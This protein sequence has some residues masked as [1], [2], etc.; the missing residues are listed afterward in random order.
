MQ[1]TKVELIYN[2]ALRERYLDKKAEFTKLANT[3]AEEKFVF[4]GTDTT[5]IHNISKEG[6]KIGGE[7][8][9][10][11]S[12]AAF[13][14]GVYTAVNPDTSIAYSRGSNMM[15]LSLALSGILGT[16]HSLGGGPQVIVLKNVH[17]LLPK[18]VVHY[19]LN[20]ATNS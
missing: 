14:R 8:V 7:G 19:H 6:F 11:K 2:V 15:L 1:V 10:I 4:H 17:Q 13:G 16:H 20:C 12:G 5:A 9:A 3:P 18:Y